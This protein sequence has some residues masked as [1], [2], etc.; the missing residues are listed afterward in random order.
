[1]HI[2]GT[3]ERALRRLGDVGDVLGDF[4]PTPSGLDHAATDLV[5]GG[6]LLLNSAEM[7]IR[8]SSD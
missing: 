2:V 6:G 7:C 4:G 8:D 5:G 1:M 3:A